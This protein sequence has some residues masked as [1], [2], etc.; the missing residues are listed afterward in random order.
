MGSRF[1]EPTNSVIKL[2][3]TSYDEQKQSSNAKNRTVEIVRRLQNSS[4]E[5]YREALRDGNLSVMLD[6]DLLA[7]G[8][9]I[10]CVSG[11][12]LLRA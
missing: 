9:K 3:D 8:C 5:V 10:S 12:D 4:A 2:A 11:N 7:L 1:P 6:I